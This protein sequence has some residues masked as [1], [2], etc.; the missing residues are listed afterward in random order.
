MKV[1]NNT[2]TDVAYDVSWANAGD[3]GSLGMGQTVENT[4]WDNQENVQVSFN[5]L[6]A[7]PSGAA[8]FLIMIDQTGEGLAV[9]I[10]ILSE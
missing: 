4:D 6:Q 2:P 1:Y 8:P 7:E 10:G 9:T 3:C 5:P